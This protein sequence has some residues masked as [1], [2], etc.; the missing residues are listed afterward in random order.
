MT[1]KQIERQI[2]DSKLHCKLNNG[3]RW[4]LDFFDNKYSSSV[5]RL[6]LFND[7]FLLLFGSIG[8]FKN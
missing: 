4:V 3:N 2:A 8:N 6:F 7:C 5:F 1:Q